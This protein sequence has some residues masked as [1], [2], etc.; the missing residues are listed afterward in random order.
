[1]PPVRERAVALNYDH[2]PGSAP[3]VVASGQGEVAQK[4]IAL[5]REAGV[6]IVQDADLLEVLAKVPVGQEIPADLFQAVAEILAFVYRANKDY[7]AR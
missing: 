3:K 2:S 7:A 5:A 4:I 1:M 6:E